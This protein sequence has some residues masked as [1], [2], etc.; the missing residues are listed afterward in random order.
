MYFHHETRQ[1]EWIEIQFSQIRN[2]T[3]DYLLIKISNEPNRIIDDVDIKKK[4][5]F[6]R[7]QNLRNQINSSKIQPKLSKAKLLVKT[8]LLL[9]FIYLLFQYELA[10]SFCATTKREEK[11]NLH[12]TFDISFWSLF[13]F[14]TKMTAFCFADAFQEGTRARVIAVLIHFGVCRHILAST[15]RCKSVNHLTQ[16]VAE[17]KTETFK[18]ELRARGSPRQTNKKSQTIYQLHRSR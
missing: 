6:V 18:K 13:H 5:P 2:T 15:W 16:M 14:H 10:T 3:N 12:I 1:K 17:I 11:N 4:T 7:L 8:L 9:L